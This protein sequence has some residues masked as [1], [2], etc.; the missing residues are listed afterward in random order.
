MAQ[1]VVPPGTAAPAPV[2]PGRGFRWLDETPDVAARYFLYSA[3]LWL[4]APV[5]VG[6]LLALFL[7]EP[8]VQ[9]HL[10]AALKPYIIF[11][12]LRPVHVNLGLLGWLSMTYAAVMLYV[13][14]RL[15]GAP[16]YSERLARLTLLLWNLVLLFGALSLLAGYNQGREY[17]EFPWLIDLGMIAVLVLLAVNVWGTVWRRTERLLY[18]SCWNWMAATAILPVLYAIGNKVWDTS[19]AYTGAT[20]AI[21]NFFWV[22]N[23]FNVW[24]TTA[25]IG[26]FLYMIPKV[27]GNPLFSHRLAIWGFASV[28]AGQHHLLYGPGPDWLEILSVAFSITAAIPNTAFLVN[29]IKTMQGRWGTIAPSLAAR[30]VVVGAIM[31]SLTCVQGIAQSFRNFNSFIHFTNWVV[32]HSHLIFVGGFSFLAFGVFYL[33]LP[34]MLGRPMA[35]LALMEWH[36]WLTL[37]G[38]T[39][40]MTSLWAAGLVQGADWASAQ[41]PFLATVQQMHGFFLVRLIAGA[42]M[43]VAQLLFAY[44]V[45]Q[46]VR[47]RAV[48][49]THGAAVQV[50][51]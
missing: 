51:A 47:A 22:H 18:V 21:V 34:R 8:T 4:L 28:W 44:N 15:V 35:S 2:V 27:S 40:F 46:T 33:L 30:C 25:G 36:F 13:T 10:P 1:T 6:L 43:V 45:W 50:V 31:Y 5:F 17:A 38:L 9:D 20:D 24:F 26:I 19:G 39:V 23:L 14:P 7:Y 29:F 32:G 37:G 11:G 48:S 12:R 49:E 41:V 16:L 3:L 42:V